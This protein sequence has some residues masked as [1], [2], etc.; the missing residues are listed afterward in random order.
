[1]LENFDPN[2]IEDE[3]LRQVVLHLMN[4][5]ENL[6][7]KV[8]EQAEEIQR[9]R[10]ENNRLKGEQGQPKI[11]ANKPAPH[12][13]SQKECR[14]SKPHR[15]ANKQAQIRID[16][17]EVLRVD[18][19]RL[20]QD[21]Q[22]KGYEEVVVQDI[23]FRTDN[24]KFRKEKYYSPSQKQTYLA[25]L[26]AGYKGQFG[27][28][29]RAWVLALYYAGGMSE[30]K[31]LEL[32]HTVGMSIS[33]GQ[34]SDFLIQDQEQ[35]HAERAAVVRAGLASSAWHHLDSTGTR[36]DGKNQHC[37]VLCNPFYTAYCTLAGK[38]R[39]S[40]L[41]VLQDGADPPFRFN[42]LALN[43]LKQLGVAHK[44]CKK[45]SELLPHE[46]DWNE[47]QLD[48]WLD[49]RLPKL[50]TK[51]RKLIKDG[52]AIAGYRTQTAYPVVELLVCD[53]APQF[54]W[55][56]V[57]LALC[58]MHEYRHYKQL[59]PRLPYHCKTLDT[60]KESFWKLYR[61][62]VA[63]QYNPEQEDA[64]SLRVEFE[65]LFE[66]TTGYQ[67][68]DER[69]ALTLAKKDHLLMVLSHPEIPLHNNPAE[70]GARQRVRK[71]DVSLQA[72][73]SEGIGAWDTF[74]TLV[75]TAK[76]L[77][78][79]IY[80]YFS[81]CIAQTNLLPRLATLIEERAKDL[82]CDASWRAGT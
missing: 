71:R 20:P 60:F 50:G 70:L 21:A 65:R 44:W 54:N 79:N 69:F 82:Q 23:D 73:T 37:H 72:R 11:K 27:P 57:E 28:G 36:V 33:A 59:M 74:Q 76:K 31:I 40:L 16:R 35:F 68:L 64:H 19:Q 55:L 15:K 46:Q 81:D 41:R 32:L 8:Q 49:E 43:L 39:L 4:L 58:W 47:N 2:M 5:V 12:L 13:S 25:A 34:L 6:H 14:E 17:V 61:K 80:Q 26:P 29:V 7:A 42:G 75:A 66:Q 45:L 9:L 1:M 51:L 22:F 63:Y 56:T 48:E 67:Q 77:E 62:L 38:D 52:L 53:D 18:Q 78:V 24:I 30:P 10:D 3:G